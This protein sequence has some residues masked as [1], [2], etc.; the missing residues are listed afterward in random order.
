MGDEAMGVGCWREKK[1]VKMR[2]RE[3]QDEISEGR[4]TRASASFLELGL[5]QART[6]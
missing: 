3:V 5:G 6:S 2:T 1:K 4:T